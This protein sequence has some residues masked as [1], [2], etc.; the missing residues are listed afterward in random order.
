MPRLLT[1]DVKAMRA[2]AGQL[3][4]PTGLRFAIPSGP[5]SALNSFIVKGIRVSRDTLMPNSHPNAANETTL[6]PQNG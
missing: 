2:A 4:L 1:P 5:F 6:R 3:A